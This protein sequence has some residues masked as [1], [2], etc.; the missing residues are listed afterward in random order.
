MTPQE[1]LDAMA[2]AEAETIAWAKALNP[3][4]TQRELHAL[5]SGFG[6]G[7]NLCRRALKA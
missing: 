6:Q 1:L 4:I 7:W 2:K 5:T 3:N